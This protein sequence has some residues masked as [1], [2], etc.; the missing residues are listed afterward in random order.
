MNALIVLLFLIPGFVAEF[1]TQMI[2]KQ[3]FRRIE[4]KWLYKILRGLAY[5]VPISI[6]VWI[7]IWIWK[8]PLGHDWYMIQS[9]EQFWQKCYEEIFMLRYVVVILVGLIVY[10]IGLRILR[11]CFWFRRLLPCIPCNPRCH[12]IDDKE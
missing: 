3:K 6:Y 10:A 7:V 4:D 5:N 8:V 12:E 11:S 9:M 2:L 1:L